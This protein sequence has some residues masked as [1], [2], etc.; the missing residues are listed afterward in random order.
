MQPSDKP[1]I[2][3]VRKEE[4]KGLQITWKD[5]LPD[6]PFERMQIETGLKA[7]G[8]TSTYSS[9]KRLLDGDDA[10]TEEEIKRIN[11][12]QSQASLAEAA[13]GFGMMPPGDPKEAQDMRKQVKADRE[14]EKKAE[15]DAP[16]DKGGDKR[17]K[18]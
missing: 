15:A 8:L 11:D 4:P 1:A 7:A 13:M 10:A 14:A 3:V 9:V 17:G 5:G 6:D 18:R 2:K 12:E 16:T